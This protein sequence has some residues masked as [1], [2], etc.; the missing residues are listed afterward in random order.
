ME[1]IFQGDFRKPMKLFKSCLVLNSN[2]F[3]L[4]IHIPLY[5][6]DTY[7]FMTKFPEGDGEQPGLNLKLQK[8]TS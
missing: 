5:I 3:L 8:W 2:I 6:Y 7:T 1:E 4:G